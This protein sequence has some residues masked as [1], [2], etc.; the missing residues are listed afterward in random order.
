MLDFRW[1]L[2]KPMRS[3]LMR[4]E[5]RLGH[6]GEVHVKTQAV[7]ICVA[8]SQRTPRATKSGKNQRTLESLEGVWPSQHLDSDLFPFKL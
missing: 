1:L 5:K 6:K 8:T 7:I 4:Q 3:V 2:K